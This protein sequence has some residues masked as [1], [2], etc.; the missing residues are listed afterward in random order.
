MFLYMHA[1]MHMTRKKITSVKTEPLE[2]C[3]CMY[4]IYSHVGKAIVFAANTIV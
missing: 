2:S 1:C 3:H 4:S